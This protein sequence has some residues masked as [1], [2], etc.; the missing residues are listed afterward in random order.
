MPGTDYNW[1]T[2]EDETMHIQELDEVK[3]RWSPRQEKFLVTS[4]EPNCR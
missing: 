4:V 3:K 1:Y 2:A